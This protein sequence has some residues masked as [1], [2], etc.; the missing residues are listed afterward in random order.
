[1]NLI[2][3]LA[4]LFSILL[5]SNVVICSIIIHVRLFHCIYL[6]LLLLLVY[7]HQLLSPLHAICR[8]FNKIIFI[9]LEQC[10]QLPYE[11]YTVVYCIMSFYANSISKFVCYFSQGFVTQ[12]L[13]LFNFYLFEVLF[14][15]HLPFDGTVTVYYHTILS[16]CIVHVAMFLLP[17]SCKIYTNYL[18][19]IDSLQIHVLPI[20]KNKEGKY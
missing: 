11:V 4:N 20:F 6:L 2:F 5:L 18:L 13:K 9:S 7:S 10:P 14:D 1:M 15:I 19:F 12:D 16:M 3:S 8:D 17:S